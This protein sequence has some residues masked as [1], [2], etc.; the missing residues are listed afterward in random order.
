MKKLLIFAF[1]TCFMFQSFAQPLSQPFTS[2][3]TKSILGNDETSGSIGRSIAH[4]DAGNVYVAGYFN[5]TINFGTGSTAIQLLNPDSYCSYLAKYDPDGS[6]I[7]AQ[8]IVGSASDVRISADAA[9]N[10][11]I[12][13]GFNGTA[14]FNGGILLNSTGD[15]DIFVTKYDTDGVLQWV[16]QIGG[17][18]SQFNFGTN[19]DTDGNIYILGSFIGSTDFDA[20]SI[21]SNKIDLF[22]AKYTT[23]G[24]FAWVSPIIGIN[25]GNHPQSL[26]MTV[27]A[28]GNLY[29]AGKFSGT[30]DFDPGNITHELSSTFGSDYFPA[31]AKYNNQGEYQWAKQFEGTSDAFANL[32]NMVITTDGY[33]LYLTGSFYGIV[34]FDLDTDVTK[35]ANLTSTGSR[36]IYVAKYN[37]VT[38][39]YQWATSSGG[40]DATTDYGVGNSIAVNTNG[41]VYVTG[42]WA[43][44]IDFDPSVTH[45]NNQT[46]AGGFDIFLTKY[47][48]SGNY[49]EMQGIGADNYEEGLS[50]SID[51]LGKINIAGYSLSNSL[52]FDN[53]YNMA[54]SDGQY[55]TFVVRYTDPAFV[56]PVTLVSFNAKAENNRVLVTWKTASEINNNHFEVERSTNG[57]GFTTI[58]TQ[59][60]QGS[61]SVPFSYIAYDYKPNPGIN[62]YRL[63]QVDNNGSENFS[64]IKA[65]NF[66]L[67]NADDAMDIYPNP[68]SADFVNIQLDTKN[69][70]IIE[71]EDL[72]GKVLISQ[73]VNSTSLNQ[74]NLTGILPGTY[75]ISAKGNNKPSIKKLIKL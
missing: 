48:A 23:N 42:A 10:V 47:D 43:G 24:V 29:I 16:K 28:A 53:S 36:D 22:I 14:N 45:A 18:N 25:N 40:P 56:L 69:Y 49:Q 33:Y 58:A 26:T 3:W 68:V 20:T 13:G 67:S 1:S 37:G 19:V 35:T 71:L 51:L 73:K 27:D 66:S 11:Y 50:I 54:G 9:G 62:Y 38:A 30:V 64:E 70:Y 61:T 8:K 2:S 17:I 4:D 72:S 63:K 46:V 55:N 15:Y 7:W 31:L 32:D 12:A 52:N 44:T 41:E 65:A 60:G 21:N 5:G 34:D 74:L 75:F 57:T 6:V 59:A 39:A